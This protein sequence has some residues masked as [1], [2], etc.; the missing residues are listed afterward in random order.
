[1]IY[2]TNKKPMKEK[3]KRFSP[4]GCFLKMYYYLNYEHKRFIR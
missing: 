4:Q 1:M 3:D 2:S